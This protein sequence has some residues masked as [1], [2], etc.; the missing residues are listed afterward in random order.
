MTISPDSPR[1]SESDAADTVAAAPQHG[2]SFL[3]ILPVAV[4][5]ALYVR[6]F[7][8]QAFV[9][10]TPSMENTVLV[11]DYVL[12][13]KFIY[14]PHSIWEERVLPF[15]SVRRGDVVVFR[16]LD[17]PSSDLIKRAVA[18]AGDEIEIRDRVLVI[19]GV[20]QTEPWARHSEP[21]VP[22]DDRPASDRL[23]RRDQLPKT[24]LDARTYFVMGDNRENSNDSRF[25]GAVPAQNLKGRALLIYWSLF[26]P[27][28]AAHRNPFQSA[29]DFFRHPRWSRMLRF[30]R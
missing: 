18:V 30:V 8:F 16:S 21:N 27:A 29:A 10:P 1:Q 23:R 26:P 22:T 9:V 4:L 25:W 5:L 28:P 2:H 24:R 3:E 6:T 14:S 15:R 12:V 17:D 19:G 7:L 11:G 20:A 13:N